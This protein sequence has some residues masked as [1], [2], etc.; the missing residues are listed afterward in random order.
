MSKKSTI[1]ISFFMVL[2]LVLGLSCATLFAGFAATEPKIENSDYFQLGEGTGAV[3]GASDAVTDI[4]LPYSDAGHIYFGESASNP[5]FVDMSIFSWN[6]QI[7]QLAVGQ[8]FAISFLKDASQKPFKGAVGVSF[9]FECVSEGVLIEYVVDAADGKIIKEMVETQSMWAYKKDGTFDEYPKTEGD[10]GYSHGMV[11]RLSTQNVIGA[12]LTLAN[13]VDSASFGGTT[14]RPAI[15]SGNSLGTTIPGEIF[16][17]REMNIKETVLVLSAGGI[18]GLGDASAADLQFTVETPADK[19]TKQYN[20]SAERMAIVNQLTD[21]KYDVQE[22]MQG[23]LSQEDYIA[24]VDGLQEMDLSSLRVRD[25]YIQA[26]VKA[27]IEAGLAALDDKMANVADAVTDY[28][29]AL[30]A[31]QNLNEVNEQKIQTAKEAREVYNEYAAYVKY[32]SGDK[33]EEIETLVKELNETL[34][35]RGEIHLQ[36]NAYEEAVAAFADPVTDTSAELIYLA[37]TARDA[38]NYAGLAQLEAEDRSDFESRIAVCDQAIEDARLLNAFDVEKY[39]IDLYKQAVTVL[40]SSNQV[41]DFKEAL[42]TRP[43]LRLDDVMPSDAAVLEQALADVDTAF[44]K[45]IVRVL[46]AWNTIYSEKTYALQDL[47]ALTQAKIDAAK[48]AAYDE[49]DFNALL[50]IAEQIE[51]DVTAA[52]EKLLECDR[53]VKAAEIRLLL[54]NYY[55]LANATIE[56]LNALNAAYEAYLIVSE[57]DLSILSSAEKTAYDAMLAEA[58]A[59]YEESALALIEPLLKAFEDS[60]AKENIGES[61]AIEEAKEA[62]AAVPSLDYLIIEEDLEDA[63]SRYDAANEILLAQTLYYAYT[64]GT[65]W[66][67]SETDEGL[68]LSNQLS[69]KDVCDGLAMIQDPLNID[70]FDFAFDFT[71]IGRIWKGEDP[72]GSG[73]Y[74]QSILVMNIMREAGKNKDETQGFSI[75]FYCNHLNELEVNIYGASTSAGEVLLASGKIGDANFTAENYVPYTVRIRIEKSTTSY[76]VYVNSLQLNVYFRDI[77]NP[78]EDRASHLP[79]FEVGSEIGANIFKDGKAYV[80]FVVFASALT[81]DAERQSAITIR[82]IGDKTFGGYVPP[83]Y[84]VSVELVSGPDKT[85][86]QKGET[87][88][89]TGIQMTVT[90]SDGSTENIPLD[91][92]KVLG[93]TSTSKGKKNVTL[94]YTDDTGVTLSKVIQVEI[95][96]KEETKTKRGCGGDIAAVSLGASALLVLACAAVLKKKGSR[97]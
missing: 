33:L 7:K 42:E 19:A 35:T 90:L 4:I 11:G 68:K 36:I 2:A 51:Y 32:L 66:T 97:M 94:S 29:S 8:S 57:S 83:V 6:V 39:K 96:D 59:A 63:Q 69:D 89:K 41:Q 1:L 21:Y 58:N 75:Y 71:E 23:T 34:L 67:L 46:E 84:A 20:A 38:V 91:K 49:D 31:L 95:V 13:G 64:S 44:G 92:I 88:D 86:Y 25:R 17:A 74:P 80:T 85:V 15:S 76:R 56:D 26:K 73:L 30:N 61:A 77:V 55:Q 5:Y 45:Q 70:G 81:S 28:S 65:S 54:V 12:K 16:T 22:A 48:A 62:R 53:A 9:V 10:E 24:M 79:E 60:V 47:S 87:F 72:V 40:S 18:N 52:T 14:N 27:E 93:F 37:E 43:T 50:E 78:D 82:M 3:P